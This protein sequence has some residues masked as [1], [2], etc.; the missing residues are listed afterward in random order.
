MMTIR[1]W[2]ENIALEVVK[3]ST[4]DERHWW[5]TSKLQKTFHTGT[6]DILFLSILNVLKEADMMIAV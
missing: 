3:S 6:F 5:V 2:E 4:M 1:L